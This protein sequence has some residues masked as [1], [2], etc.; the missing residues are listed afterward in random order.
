[1]QCPDDPGGV[2]PTLVDAPAKGATSLTTTTRCVWSVAP[3]SPTVTSWRAGGHSM[4]RHTCSPTTS[5]ERHEA[6]KPRL[7][8]PRLPVPGV[9]RGI[10]HLPP[11]LSGGGAAAQE[12]RTRHL[13]RLHRRVPMP[14]VPRSQRRLQAAAPREGA[15]SPRSWSGRLR[16]SPLPV[17]HLPGRVA[18]LQARLPPAQRIDPQPAL[19]SAPPTSQNFRPPHAPPA[20]ADTAPLTASQSVPSP[21]ANSTTRGGARPMAD[22]PLVGWRTL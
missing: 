7:L 4:A 22:R 5:R 1:M 11:Q 2:G 17:R 21:P 10:Q 8:P 19:P 15:R 6:R 12:G 16:Q 13:Q 14:G 20:Q 18:R 9:S 3:N